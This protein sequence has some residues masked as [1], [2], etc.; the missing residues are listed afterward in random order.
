M[1]FCHINGI[2]EKEDRNVVAAG[3]HHD[4]VGFAI[5]IEFPD[6]DI[7]RARSRG[8]VGGGAEGAGAG[9][10]ED[11]HVVTTHIRNCKVRLA[12]SIDI[13]DRDGARVRPRGKVR[14]CAEGAG[15][16][17]QGGVEE[18]RDVVAVKIRHGQVG[19]AIAI[20]VPDR[21]GVRVCPRGE[22]GGG[23]EGAGTGAEEDRDVVAVG[24]RHGQVGL[25]IAIEIPDR[26]GERA[27][28]TAKLVAT[29][30]EPVPSPRR[31]ETLAPA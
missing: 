19:L 14:G 28:P 23:A 29:P 16:V 13:A 20:E 10:E 18:D 30:K 2:K 3:I 26:D 21:D 25:A 11:R 24:I 15:R 31:I 12:I 17:K 4:Q 8:E 7:E 27:I 1:S 5:P 9:A 6:L 22:V